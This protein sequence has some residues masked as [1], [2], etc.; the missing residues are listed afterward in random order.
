[1]TTAHSPARPVP[2]PPV[3]T[4]VG[5]AVPGLTLPDELLGTVREGGFDPRTG[6]TGRDL[7]HKDRASRLALRA[8][9][10]ALRDAGL[11]GEDGYRGTGD[12]T[13]V[14]V[15]TNAGILDSVCSFAD[16]IA[17]DTVTGLSPLGLPQTSSNVV[18]GS[19]A[20]AHG[21]RGPSVT[22][23]NGP[24]SGLDAL[25][26]ARALIVAGRADSALV[27]GVEPHGE[28]V[29]KLLG[30]DALDGAAALVV[31]SA[32]HAAARGATVRAALTGCA[33]AGTLDA[34]VAAARAGGPGAR[35][36][37]AE[38]TSPD[39]ALWLTDLADDGAPGPAGSGSRRLDPTAFL[40]HSSGARGVLQAAAA[41]AHLDGHAADT[42]LATCGGPGDDAVAAVVLGGPRRAF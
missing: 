20:M 2:G 40:G 30:G 36:T 41:V 23:C 42:V 31:E 35:P 26:W 37:A 38:R 7:R 3:V 9:A 27:I 6:L 17:R 18:A 12:R 11:L 21:L 14:L 34:A 10:P 25:Y 33:R 8:A 16:I 28:A 29:A 22:L 5:L 24:T 4:G 32:A 19:V 13:A 39:A 1:M 15:S